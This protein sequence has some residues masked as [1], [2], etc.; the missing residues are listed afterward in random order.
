MYEDC[1]AYVDGKCKILNEGVCNGTKCS[2]YK[3]KEQHKAELE[4]YPMVDYSK[5]SKEEKL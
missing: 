1:F 3:S 4:K 2:F 5:R